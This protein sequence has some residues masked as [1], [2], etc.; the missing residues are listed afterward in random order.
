[1]FFKKDIIKIF[2]GAIDFEE[3]KFTKKCKFC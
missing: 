1:M 2:N 3:H